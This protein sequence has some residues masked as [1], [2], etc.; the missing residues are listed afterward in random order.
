MSSAC[1]PVTGPKEDHLTEHKNADCET[2]IEDFHCVRGSP[3]LSNTTYRQCLWILV[4]CTMGMP[5]DLRVRY[6]GDTLGGRVLHYMGTLEASCAIDWK[7]R[8]KNMD[9]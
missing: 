9:V 1:L 8:L 2:F 3:K 4:C 6:Y 5:L 7:Y